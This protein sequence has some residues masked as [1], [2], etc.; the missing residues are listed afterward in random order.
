MEVHTMRKDA[1]LKLLNK[2]GMSVLEA[3]RYDSAGPAFVSY[4]YFALKNRVAEEFPLSKIRSH[5]TI[6]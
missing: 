5:E 3:E 1:V 4:R 2:E 6:I